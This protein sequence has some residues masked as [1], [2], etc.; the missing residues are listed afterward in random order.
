MDARNVKLGDAVFAGVPLMKARPAL[1]EKS[2]VRPAG[3]DPA[4]KLIHVMD[5]SVGDNTVL[6][7]KYTL[8]LGIAIFANNVG[9]E[10]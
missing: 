2:R 4:T 10:T 6:A 9:V 5:T 8:L 3:N 7:P 1:L